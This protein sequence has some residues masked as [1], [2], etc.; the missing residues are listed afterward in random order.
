MDLAH[1]LHCESG[2]RGALR[3][4]EGPLCLV[5]ASAAVPHD[6]LRDRRGGTNSLGHMLYLLLNDD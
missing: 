3:R 2:T 4:F 6:L 5:V 1:S